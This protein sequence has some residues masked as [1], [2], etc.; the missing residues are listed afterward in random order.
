MTPSLRRRGAFPKSHL[1]LRQHAPGKRAGNFGTAHTGWRST[2]ESSLMPKPKLPAELATPQ[3]K[4]FYCRNKA[5][6]LLSAAGA[7]RA[8]DNKL[9][10]LNLSEQWMKLALFYEK[11]KRR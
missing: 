11:P 8:T 4:A 2:P 1:L 6:E 9:A 5:V 10:L 7:A 3:E